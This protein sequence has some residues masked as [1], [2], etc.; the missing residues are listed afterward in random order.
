MSINFNYEVCNTEDIVVFIRVWW[1]FREIN[2]ILHLVFYFIYDIFWTVRD[3]SFSY[4][5]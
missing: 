4:G 3:L 2:F 5:G 1:F